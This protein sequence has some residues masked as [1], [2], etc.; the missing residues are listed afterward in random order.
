MRSGQVAGAGARR[1]LLYAGGCIL[2]LTAGACS[3]ARP[4]PPLPAPQPPSLIGNKAGPIVGVASWYGPGFDGH[5]TA[6][7]E[8][9]D[10]DDLTAASVI[11]PLGSRVVVTDLDNGRSVNVRINDRGPFVKGRKIDLSRGAA[12]A[13]GMVRPGTAPVKLE[14]LNVPQGSRPVG[15]PLEY[16]VQVGSFSDA[17]H[18][19]SVRRRLAAHYRDIRIDKVDLGGRVFYRVRMGAFR[20]RSDAER[21]A[22]EV[23]RLG[24]PLIIVSE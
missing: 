12:R 1:S 6:S 4:L 15:A 9:Y 22:R 14:A 8:I 16:Y 18:A 10:Q 20:T 3:T 19:A 23:G 21:R 5:R 17:G 2:T 7:G 13:L 24:Q 11:F